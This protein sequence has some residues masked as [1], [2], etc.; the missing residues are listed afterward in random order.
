MT[1]APISQNCLCNRSFSVFIGLQGVQRWYSE[2]GKGPMVHRRR[3]NLVWLIAAYGPP[4]RA[5]LQIAAGHIGID[6]LIDALA[7]ALAAPA[8][9]HGLPIL[10]P[11]VARR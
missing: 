9:Q 5:A 6:A 1:R 4:S 7:A 2:T 3:E 11:R 10:P 8:P